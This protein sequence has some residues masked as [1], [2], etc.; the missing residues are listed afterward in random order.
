MTGKWQLI[1]LSRGLSLDEVKYYSP[2]ESWETSYSRF[3][4]WM[5]KEKIDKEKIPDQ[6]GRLIRLLLN[7]GWEPFANSGN[8]ISFRKLADS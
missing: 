5:F 8:H 3:A 2:K 4:E 1:I 6:C 7:D